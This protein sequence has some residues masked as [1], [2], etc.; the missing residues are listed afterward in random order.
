M[1]EDAEEARRRG[2]P[3]LAEILGYG[4]SYDPSRGRDGERSARAVARAIRGALD[5]AGLAPEAIDA[6]SAS[7]NGSVAGD[8]AEA[9]AI[10]EVFG[11]ELPT[12]A[13][14]SMLGEALGASGA[15]QT[16]ALL[17]AMA[18]GVLPGVRGLKWPDEACSASLVSAEPR[19]IEMRRGLVTALGFDGQACALVVARRPVDEGRTVPAE[20]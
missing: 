19:R 13:V 17:Q 3:A 9:F 6:A 12:T 10:A 5:D 2:A 18:T 8:R 1:L 11:A 4:L 15:F 16:V 20:G 7:A 14:K